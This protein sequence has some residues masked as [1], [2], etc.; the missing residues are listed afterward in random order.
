[1]V[2]PKEILN[3]AQIQ[4]LCNITEV[5]YKFL[6]ASKFCMLKKSDDFSLFSMGHIS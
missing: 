5:T 2:F 3:N 4:N 6:I 1:M